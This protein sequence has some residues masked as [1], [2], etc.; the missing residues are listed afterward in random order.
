[1]HRLGTFKEGFSALEL[2]H[3]DLAGSQQRPRQHGHGLCAG[4]LGL[5]LD[6]AAELFVQGSTALLAQS[7]FL[8]EG[9]RLVMVKSGPL[10]SLRLSAKAQRFGPPFWRNALRLYSTSAAVSA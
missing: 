9:S 2:A 5:G 4:Q 8:Y 1:V 10:A 7:E 6:T 3:L